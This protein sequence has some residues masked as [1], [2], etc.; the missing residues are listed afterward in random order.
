MF[1]TQISVFVENNI[2]ELKE[3]TSA[4]KDAGIDIRALSLADTTDFGVLRLIVDDPEK[5]LAALSEREIPVAKTQVIAASLSDV[6]GSFHQVL[7]VLSDAGIS[8][9]YTYAF[10]GPKAEA[11]YVILRVEDNEKAVEALTK[12]GITILSEKDIY[13]I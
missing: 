2:G 7:E 12:A 1:I 5:A 11:A 13:G 3:I 6:P 4:L 9:E 10:L 8:L